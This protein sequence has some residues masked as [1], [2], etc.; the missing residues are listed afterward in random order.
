MFPTL[1]TL[2]HL[3]RGS[4]VLLILRLT[5]S[6]TAIVGPPSAAPTTLA[7]VPEVLSARA[8]Y[9]D[10]LG[11]LLDG[12]S[13]DGHLQH[14]ILEAGVDLALVGALRQRHAPS[15]R[16][17]APL[18]DMVVTTILFLVDLVLARDGQDPVLQGDV[19]IVLLESR[20]LGT[21]QQVIVLS[22]HVHSRRPLGELL[23]ASL[24]PPSATQAP[25]RLVERSEEHTSE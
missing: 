6:R 10:A 14:S 2:K 4:E 21:D 23:L 13:L 22:E 1:Q 3:P 20:K 12:G 18:P 25:K 15:E 19:H 9:L 11:G 16:T 17:K 24:T 7:C 5:V 8:L